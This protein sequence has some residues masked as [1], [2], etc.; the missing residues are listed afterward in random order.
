MATHPLV[1]EYDLS[2]TKYFV[3]AAAPLGPTLEAAVQARLGIKTKQAYG[4]TELSPLVHYTRD[5][6]ERP[7]ASGHLVPNT[8]LRVV[9]PTT[10]ADLGPHQIGELWYRGPQVMLGYLNNDDATRATITSCGFL[11]TGDLGYVDDDGNLFVV[12]RLK[13]LI[14][15]KGYQVAP[16]ELEDVIMKH[17]KV[18]D[19]ACIRGYTG[20]GDEVPKAC[21]VAKP[22]SDLS[23]EELMEFVA[24]HV[25][26][27]KK[28]RQV[29]FVPSIPKSASGKILRRQLQAPRP[30]H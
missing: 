9:C 30:Q 20:N 15:Y 18:L 24:T 25:A 14:K 12:D 4:M 29:A 26:P 11:K 5:G 6:H 22:N 2:A 27:H 10:G 1:D 23:A 28:V 3:S 13:E 7:A 8:E 16:A 21:V 19:V 17:P